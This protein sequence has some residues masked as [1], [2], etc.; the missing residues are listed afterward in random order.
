MSIGVISLLDMRFIGDDKNEL[1]GENN[2]HDNEI[3]QA[4][5][6]LFSG[7]IMVE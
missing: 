3:I 6:N 5:I 4:K 7:F 2:Y 1:F